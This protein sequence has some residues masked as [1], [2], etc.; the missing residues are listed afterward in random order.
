MNIKHKNM[1]AVYYYPFAFF[2]LQV[3]PVNFISRLLA[4]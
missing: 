3:I 2:Y 1:I 4:L